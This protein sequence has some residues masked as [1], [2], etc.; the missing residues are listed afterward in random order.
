MVCDA[1]SRIYVC[2]I[3]LPSISNV[4]QSVLHARHDF[5]LFWKIVVTDNTVAHYIEI[6]LYARIRFGFG[7]CVYCNQFNSLHLHRAALKIFWNFRIFH[8]QFI[9]LMMRFIIVRICCFLHRFQPFPQLRS[10]SAGIVAG[11]PCSQKLKKR[12][13]THRTITGFWSNM[14]V[15]SVLT[16]LFDFT[17]AK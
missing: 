10:T 6:K 11:N 8:H 2:M 5:V 13:F 12:K 4:K 14:W 15:E 3:Y 16:R 1:E 17:G 7:L 9:R